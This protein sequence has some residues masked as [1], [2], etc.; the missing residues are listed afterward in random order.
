MMKSTGLRQQTFQNNI[1]SYVVHSSLGF[2]PGDAK[3]IVPQEGRVF[4]PSLCLTN[5]TEWDKHYSEL[6]DVLCHNRVGLNNL[7]KEFCLSELP[8][9]YSAM[10]CIPHD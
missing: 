6:H 1:G 5:A 2:I 4:S 3:C 9:A 8:N 7:G 10:I